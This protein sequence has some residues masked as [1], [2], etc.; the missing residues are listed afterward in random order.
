[1]FN[2]KKFY[3]LENG[4]QSA[5]IILRIAAMLAMPG[6]MAFGQAPASTD[7][8]HLEM[9]SSPSTRSTSTVPAGEIIREID[10]PSNGDR[11]LLVHNA[12]HPAGPGL[13]LLVSLVHIQ[14]GQAVPGTGAEPVAP[15]IRAG[16]R[17]IVEEN[18]PVVEA[19]L[20][21]VAMSPALAGHPFN[22][23]LSIG[24]RVIRAVASGPGRAVF[25]EEAAR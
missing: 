21:A 2:L 18:T 15:V 7:A 6:S 14:T 13:L 17:V 20:E 19:R 12:N 24:G 4:M 22:A 1:M 3:A 11:W 25:L 23:R 5:R 8:G 16:D 10:D 9:L